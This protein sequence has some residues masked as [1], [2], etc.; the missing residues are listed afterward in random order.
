MLEGGAMTTFLRFNFHQNARCQNADIADDD[1][2][3]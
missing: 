3:S 1:V 2:N